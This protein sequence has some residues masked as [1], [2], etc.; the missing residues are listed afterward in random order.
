[1]NYCAEEMQKFERQLGLDV[2]SFSDILETVRKESHKV[3]E[4]TVDKES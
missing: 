2:S 4:Q 3:K 1:M